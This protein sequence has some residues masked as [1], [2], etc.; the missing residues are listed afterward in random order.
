MK[1]FLL[2]LMLSFMGHASAQSYLI[3]D[4]GSTLT[5][6]KSGFIY[7]FGHYAYPHKISL[8]GGVFFIEENAILA[9]IDENG[10]LYRKYEYI[11]EKILGKGINY[12][13]SNEGELYTIDRKG[14][15]KI[16]KEEDFKRVT[17]F[18][19]RYF[20]VA[21]DDG[22]VEVV[23]IS[24]DGEFTRHPDELIKL[25]DIVSLGGAYF[26]NRRGVVHTINSWGE[27]L[28]HP[29]QRVGLIERRGGNFFTDSSG[30]IYTI[31]EAGEL[32][33]PAVPFSLSVSNIIKNAANYFIDLQGR[34]FVVNDKGEVYEKELA[35]FDFKQAVVISL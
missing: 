18:G 34:L 13:L 35:N 29:E 27:I 1:F 16:K 14:A 12:F 32:I 17:H 5:T 9:T 7:D 4:N 23:T 10:M 8:K 31:N 30:F 22:M 15:V 28:S 20:L 25:T 3:M 11:P 26:M 33:S 21:R 6:D 24:L 19:G 2:S